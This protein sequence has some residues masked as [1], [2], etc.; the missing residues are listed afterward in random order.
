MGL[1]GITQDDEDDVH[2]PL[3]KPQDDVRRN[4]IKCLAWCVKD[5]LYRKGVPNHGPGK[6]CFTS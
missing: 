5:L 3:K 1:L 4:G 2:S 6:W